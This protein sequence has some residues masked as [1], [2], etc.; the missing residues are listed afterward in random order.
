MAETAPLNYHYSRGLGKLRFIA[1]LSLTCG[2]CAFDSKPNKESIL[3]ASL[4]ESAKQVS[5]VLPSNNTAEQLVTNMNQVKENNQIILQLLGFPDCPNSPE[6]LARLTKAKTEL[7]A[8][9]EIEVIDLMQL[10]AT[11]PRL[12]YGAP[13][14][15]INGID[16]MGEDP[17][18]Q[19]ALRCRIYP[20]GNLPTVEEIIQQLRSNLEAK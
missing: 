15:L 4:I 7:S 18:A 17:S 10:N 1:L 8:K 6:L 5:I 20:D 12:H 16:L 14:I 19:G 13:T 9:F 3:N 2:G 11:D